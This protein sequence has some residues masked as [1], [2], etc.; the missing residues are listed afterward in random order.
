MSA[1]AKKYLIT[2]ANGQL[3]RLA[4]QSLIDKVPAS[5]VIALVRKPEAGTD[6]SALGV[7]VRIGSY[8]DLASLEA[9]FVGVDNLLLISSSE[10]GQRLPQHENVIAAAKKAGV[11]FIAYTSLLRADSSPLGLAME[12]IAT[13]KAII[14][15]GIPYAFLRNSWYLENYLGSIGPALEHGAVAGSVGEGRIAAAARADYAEAA[16]VVL[17]NSDQYINAVLELAGDESFTLSDLAAAISEISGKPV[18]YAYMPED[19]YKAMLVQVGLPEGFAALLAESDVGA[20]KGGLFDD[21]KTLSS[22]IGRPTTSLKTV[23]AA[24]MG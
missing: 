14:A 5:Q 15:S 10:V 11:G 19:A 21:S 8:D 9:A 1:N 12:H 24:A 6:L 23:L 18:V 22:I 2:G 16:A 4:V 3:G 7:D 13:E 17:A 20:S